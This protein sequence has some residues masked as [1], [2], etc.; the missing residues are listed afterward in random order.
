[1]LRILANGIIK[2]VFFAAKI[3]NGSPVC[4]IASAIDPAG[5]IL[6]FEDE[7]SLLTW[8]DA[9]DLREMRA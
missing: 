8:S 4:G 2:L 1:M 7:D 3:E 9:I 6:R 5:I